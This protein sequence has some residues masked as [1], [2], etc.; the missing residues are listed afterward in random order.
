MK[1]ETEIRVEP[2]PEKRAFPHARFWTVL[3]F[4][5]VLA[6][7]AA[8]RLAPWERSFGPNGVYFAGDGD[9]YYHALRAERLARDWPRVPWV[10]S[11]MDYP[12]GAE[13]PWPPLFD[14]VIATAAVATGPA[15]Q[16][17]VGAVAAV[18]PVILGLALSRWWLSWV[19]LCSGADRGSTRRC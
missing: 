9:S 12:Y 13:I 15:T 5:A 18:V 19:R 2:I 10:D 6:I 4:A 17:H 14:Q 11:G 7:G 1:R 8:V 3:G 16:E